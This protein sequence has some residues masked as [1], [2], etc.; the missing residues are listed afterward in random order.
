MQN[1]AITVIVPFY[2]VQKYFAK[3]LDSIVNQSFKDLEIILIDDC[4][5]DNSIKIAQSFADKDSRIRI[6]R[7]KK[8][9]GQGYSRNLG[10]EQAKGEYIAFVDADDWLEP[11]MYEKLYTKAIETDSDIVKCNFKLIYE[12]RI[13][14]YNLDNICPDYSKIYTVKDFPEKF[15]GEY[16]TSVW[17]C[18]YKKSFIVENNIKYDCVKF[19]D[20][21]FFWQSMILAQ[22]ISFIKKTLYNY[23]KINIHSD[24]YNNSLYKAYY[25]N[26]VAISKMIKDIPFL[27]TAFL[28]YVCM[29][30]Q[31]SFPKTPLLMRKDMFY[32][33]HNL[34]KTYDEK[35]YPSVLSFPCVSKS[36]KYLFDG[37]YYALNNSIIHKIRKTLKYVY[38]L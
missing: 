38:T 24:T 7:N 11:D 6:I 3:C 10:I 14:I 21:M 12:D 29:N 30:F 27:H 22:R 17:N 26:C 23:I 2:K 31:Y 37:V 8:N 28:I 34:I 18:L 4:G 25:N 1:P 19:E 20:M 5:N 13:E 33:Y 15:L 9:K 35:L 16:M 36:T 32:L